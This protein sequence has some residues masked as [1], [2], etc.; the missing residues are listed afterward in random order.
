MPNTPTSLLSISKTDVTYI[1]ADNRFSISGAS[2]A[3]LQQAYANYG[4]LI[5]RL[6]SNAGDVDLDIIVPQVPTE[7]YQ[8]THSNGS[9]GNA[10]VYQSISGGGYNDVYVKW[11]CTDETAT[12]Y[13]EYAAND[14]GSCEYAGGEETPPDDAIIGCMDD[15]FDNYNPNATFQ[16]DA[17]Y[18]RNAE[19]TDIPDGADAQVIAGLGA[20]SGN[21]GDLIDDTIQ[22]IQNLQTAYEEAMANQED[23]VSQADVDAI[24]VQLDDANAQLTELL[25]ADGILS[26]IDDAV[27]LAES[28]SYPYNSTD[29]PSPLLALTQDADSVGVSNAYLISI[30][31]ALQ[32]ISAY[33]T[34]T[35]DYGDISAALATA[36]ETTI[37][38]LQ[39]QIDEA[40]NSLNEA[41]ADNEL[42]DSDIVDLENVISM[43][44]TALSALSN[45]AP[46]GGSQV[47]LGGG[48]TDDVLNLT[49]AYDSLVTTYNS[50][51]ALQ[52]GLEPISDV[53]M[54]TADYEQ[55][56]LDA[57]TTALEGYEVISEVSLTQA[58]Y[59]AN[60]SSAV[61]AALVGMEEVS[62]V[63]MTQVELDAALTQAATDALVGMEEISEVSLTQTQYDQNIQNA[64]DAALV[65][66]EAVSDVSMT[67]AEFDQAIVE[68]TTAGSDAAIQGLTDAGI[69][70]NQTDLD[71]YVADYVAAQQLSTPADVDAAIS[72]AIS[73]YITEFIGGT[74]VDATL[75]T[76]ID[77]EV[78]SAVTTALVGMIADTGQAAE[79][80]T[81]E[82]GLTSAIEDLATAQTTIDNLNAALDLANTGGVASEETL[83]AAWSL[84]D[85]LIEQAE[86][87]FEAY[88]EDIAAYEAFYDELGTSMSRL[89]AF[90]SDNYGYT[91][92]D[93]SS[94]PSA[95]AL[96]QG[97]TTGDGSEAY[98]TNQYVAQPFSGSTQPNIFMNFAGKTIGVSKGFKQ[99]GG[100]PIHHPDMIN[101]AGTEVETELS[102]QA[103]KI[104]WGTGIVL[105]S[106][107]LYKL[108]KSK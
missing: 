8:F 59:D 39:S 26:A 14:D 25:G 70:V 35:S 87:Q 85:S 49:A 50:L 52:S 36:L 71:T 82:A 96:P 98:L 42:L 69:P 1:A 74:Q 40:T 24:Q 54:T 17:S 92:Y 104:I 88:A 2:G 95:S 65:G 55:A 99:F 7:P 38:D 66:M 76:Y 34:D 107:G 63:S 46:T 16:P 103:K 44:E 12:N 29:N 53:S 86:T 33:A 72:T 79:I 19:F 75:T 78:S 97:L 51:V 62:E 18:C 57:A 45:V 106:L 48:L 81:L 108:I 31:N 73:N 5:I 21:Y 60:I 15:S 27:S 67:T 90:L 101:A 3:A 23:G 64:V 20:I 6:S 94:I 41:L 28:G 89:E 84:I 11:G 102:D 37:P 47:S 100:T 32:T 10:D 56:L 13:N 9:N 61:D 77:G 83:S 43:T 4:D 93:T 91:A 80:T 58:E 68:A 30:D 22:L 105:A